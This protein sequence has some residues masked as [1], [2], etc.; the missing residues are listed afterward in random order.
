MQIPHPCT[1][2]CSHFSIRINIYIHTSLDITE[3][4]DTG[5]TEHDSQRDRRILQQALSSLH[6]I[7]IL[8]LS[9]TSRVAHTRKHGRTHRRP[10][11]NKLLINLTP[12]AV[13]PPT[14]FLQV[15]EKQT[16]SPAG[17]RK[18]GIEQTDKHGEIRG[19]GRGAL[20]PH[21]RLGSHGR[22]VT[23]FYLFLFFLDVS[24][25]DAPP[26]C[27]ARSSPGCVRGLTS[28]FDAIESPPTEQIS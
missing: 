21:P 13:R 16:P 5:Q 1:C 25:S 15:A 28:T 24:R 23:F 19:Q 18:E 3:H 22:L 17:K 27:S 7:D 14:S 12:L 26:R 6:D 11:R 2:V 4:E 20:R 10:R 8:L 9:A